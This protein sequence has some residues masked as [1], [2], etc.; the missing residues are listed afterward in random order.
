MAERRKRVGIDG[1]KQPPLNNLTVFPGK[2]PKEN[3]LD[4]DRI[5]RMNAWRDEELKDYRV[6]FTKDAKKNPTF[7]EIAE[8]LLACDG[9]IMKSAI[10]LGISYSRINK[11]IKANPK[12]KDIQQDAV[13]AFLD[14]AENKLRDKILAGDTSAIIFALNNKGSRRGW[15]TG[16]SGEL[17]DE[18]PV[19]FSYELALP[20]GCTLVGPDGK[21]LMETPKDDNPVISEQKAENK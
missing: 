1:T 12:L 18:K 5:E 14:L 13:E 21:P 20:P 3:L 15:T 11:L 17:V 10:R 9:Y 8:A 4:P 7:A 19:Q 2:K 6:R 16:M